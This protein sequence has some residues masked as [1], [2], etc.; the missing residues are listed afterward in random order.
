MSYALISNKQ[1]V[2]YESFMLEALEN[3]RKCNVIS[4]AVVAFTKEGETQTGYWQMNM[5]EKEHAAA[6]I[7]YD[8]MDDFIKANINRYRNLPDEPD[9]EIEGEE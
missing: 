8:A 1:P 9:E 2:E 7:R 4:I 3:L 6:A 5:A